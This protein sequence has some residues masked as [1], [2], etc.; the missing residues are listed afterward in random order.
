MIR[1]A[2]KIIKLMNVIVEINYSVQRNTV[3][4]LKKLFKLETLFCRK[5]KI[6]S[7]FGEKAEVNSHF[8]L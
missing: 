4:T 2:G 7:G 1:K 5:N 3:Y 6:L 8:R